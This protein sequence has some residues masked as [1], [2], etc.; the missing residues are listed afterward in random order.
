MTSAWRSSLQVAPAMVLAYLY[1]LG[2]SRK[3]IGSTEARA[4]EEELLGVSLVEH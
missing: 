2:R 1:F 3:Q 4:E